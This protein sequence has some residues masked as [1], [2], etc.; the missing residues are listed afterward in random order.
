MLLSYKDMNIVTGCGFTPNIIPLN[1]GK[2]GEDLVKNTYLS[3][4]FVTVNQE[5]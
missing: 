2:S 3:P 4:Y 5:Q 1:E